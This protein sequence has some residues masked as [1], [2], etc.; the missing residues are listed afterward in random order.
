[1]KET[2]TI[3]TPRLLLRPFVSDDALDV[4]EWT[5]SL[6]VTRFL[7]WH[8]NRDLIT[9]KKIVAKWVRGKR[10]YSWAVNKESETIGEV[11][12]IKDLPDGGFEFGITSKEKCWGKG[13]MKEA[14]FYAISFLFSDNLYSYGYAESDERNV[15]AHHLL[16]ALGFS[17]SETK[18]GVL[19]EKKNE[20]I[21][22]ACFRLAK[23]NFINKFEEWKN[24]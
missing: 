1:M 18:R 4:Y 21:D 12:V 13:Y 20:I 11:Q 14:S 17:K 7:W 8:P 6:E 5:S 22:V 3:L 24:K 23:E 16:E 10:N 9:T 15:R 2:P 19:I